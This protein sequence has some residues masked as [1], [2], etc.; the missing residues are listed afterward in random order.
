MRLLVKLFIFSVVST[1]VMSGFTGINELPDVHDPTIAYRTSVFMDS[2]RAG[3]IPPVWNNSLNYGYGYPLNLYYAPLI[4]IITSLISLI[5]SNIVLAVKISLWLITFMGMWGVSKLLSRYNNLAPVL[6]ATA[7]ALLPYHASSLYV[8]GSYAEYLSLNIIPWALYYWTTSLSERKN[9][10]RAILT[11]SLLLISHNTIPFIVMPV[12]LLISVF[13]NKNNAK[14]IIFTLTLS[15]LLPA[16]F[17]IPVIFERG[18]VQVDRIASSTV[19]TDHFVNLNQLWYSPWGYGGSSPGESDL[20]SF[21]LGKGQ[22]VL[23]LIGL[24]IALIKKDKYALLITIPLISLLIS[25]LPVSKVFWDLLPSLRILQFPWRM[26][27][28]ATIGI[29][30]AVGFAATLNKN[31]LNNLLVIF[32][33]LGLVITNYVYFR[34]WNKLTYNHDILTS[35]SNL[36][37]LVANKIPEYLPVWMPDFPESEPNDGLARNSTS[38]TGRIENKLLQTITIQTAYMPHWRLSLN[39]YPTDIIPNPD[40]TIRTHAVVPPGEY[41]VSLTWH[42]TTVEKIGVALSL[43]ALV[44]VLGL[45]L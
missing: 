41:E 7:F 30:L 35:K 36:Y 34:P 32:M 14:Q 39:G 5:T 26:I 43:L 2:I 31:R 12:I 8:R 42:K 4:T 28:V 29:S 33:A 25:V 21:M 17:L 1:L 16:A 3:Q 10:A 44:V 24:V 13:F 37:P 18:L 20:M 22:V 15:L 19:L 40:G 45:A 27:G 11:T 38:V 9:M 6:A 23:A